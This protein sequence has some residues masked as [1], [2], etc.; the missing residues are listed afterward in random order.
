M[1]RK[2]FY[3]FHYVPDNWRASIVRNI[4]SIEGNQPVKDNDWETIASGVNKDA[5]IEAWIASQMK[6]RTCTIVLV[7]QNTANRKWI[8]HEIIQSWNNGMGIVG[9]RIHGLKDSAGNIAAPGNNP[10]DYITFSHE[11]RKLST[12][13]KCY[14]PAGV[15]SQERYAWI[16]QHLSN[17]VEEAVNIRA[18]IN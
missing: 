18:A 10:F 8:N 3:S 13:V 12:V 2:C 5:K 15:T 16:A 7:G 17:A 11:N 9:I 6:G 4:R 14:S 1:A